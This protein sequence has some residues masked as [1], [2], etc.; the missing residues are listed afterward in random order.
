LKEGHEPDAL[1]AKELIDFCR[2]K[3]AGYKRPKRIAFIK[4]E[5]MPRT[6]TGKILHRVLKN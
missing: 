6:S 3:I 2:G 1:L 5:E 4:D